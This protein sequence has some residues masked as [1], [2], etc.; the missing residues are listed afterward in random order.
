MEEDQLATV[1]ID[2]LGDRD[3]PYRHYSRE[4]LSSPEARDQWVD[5]DLLHMPAASRVAVTTTNTDNSEVITLTHVARILLGGQEST[6]SFFIRFHLL[7]EA[8]YEFFGGLTGSFKGTP[9]R[10]IQFLTSI[11]MGN[12]PDPT[13][14]E[15]DN[16]INDPDVSFSFNGIGEGNVSAK[17]SEPPAQGSRTGVLHAACNWWFSGG[18][19]VG[20]SGGGVVEASAETVISLRL[21]PTDTSIT[22]TT[23]D[24][25]VCPPA[26]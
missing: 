8:S 14:F 24:P 23:E 1:L 13:Y 12:A 15:T 9:E 22:G 18:S 6:F 17:A 7:E 11:Q 10:N 26:G 4:R 3:L 19:E 25:L 2:W 20:V 5:P 21:T 16:T